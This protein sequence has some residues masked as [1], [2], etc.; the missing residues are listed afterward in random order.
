MRKRTRQVEW[1]VCLDKC[2]GIDQPWTICWLQEWVERVV[3]YTQD[4]FNTHLYLYSQTSVC[5]GA[6]Y[7]HVA[8]TTSNFTRHM[9]TIVQSAYLLH[10]M[11]KTADNLCPDRLSPPYID[12][13]A[14]LGW[15]VRH[16]C[17]QSSCPLESWLTF[18]MIRGARDTSWRSITPLQLEHNCML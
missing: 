1:C 10:I 6:G 9:W 3:Q 5:T 15:P 13:L 12:A 18:S 4:S 14:P 8:Q 11:E 2:V 7:I 16:R 17:S